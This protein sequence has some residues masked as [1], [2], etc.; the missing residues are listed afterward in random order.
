MA[1]KCL[2]GPN[3]DANN[4]PPGREHPFL[5]R[6]VQGGCSQ[7]GPGV[8]GAVSMAA[9]GQSCRGEELAPRRGSVARGPSTAEN[10]GVAEKRP[11]F[12]GPGGRCGP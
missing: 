4:H 6:C 3:A 1:R 9:P 2:P 7:Q 5:V 12:E 11:R 8:L 10:V